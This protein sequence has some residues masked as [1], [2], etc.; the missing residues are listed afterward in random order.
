[1]TFGSLYRHVRASSGKTSSTW[2]LKKAL[3][4][5]IVIGAL[6]SVTATGTLAILNSQVSNV[7]GSVASGTLTFDN[8]VN[9]GTACYSFAGPASPG[10]VNN[11]CQAL[12]ASSSLDYPGVP[13]VANVKITNDGSIDAADLSI[14]MPSCTA[15]A[16]P[17]APSPGGA[18]PCGTNGVQLYVQ[19]TTASGTPT[20]CWF[21]LH[22]GS[23]SF[24]ASSLHVF[25]ANVNSTTSAV[26]LGGGPAHGQ[27]RYFQIGMELPSNASNA[28]Q[29]EEAVFAL[30]WH[31]SA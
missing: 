10:N 19:E 31:M 14:Y 7:G 6:S 27:A 1:V 3:A 22:A 20:F 2:W 15:A 25:A 18:D 30:T 21:P 4:S 26:H 5:L 28:L 23:C 8:A 11:G 24:V 12:F 9:S 13:T 29:G 17:G 16:T